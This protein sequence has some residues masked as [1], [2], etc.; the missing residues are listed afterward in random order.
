MVSQSVG[1]GVDVDVDVPVGRTAKPAGAR[2]TA[3]L[4]AFTLAT[5]LADG[6]TKIALPVLATRST[7]SPALISLV[8]LTLTLPWLLVALPVGVLVDRADRRRLLWLADGLRLLTIGGLIAIVLGGRATLGVLALGGL[9]LGVAEVIALTATSALIPA[10]VPRADRER[11]NALITGAETAANEFAGPFVGGL[12]LAAGTGLALGVTWVAYL[13]ASLL[14]LLLTGRFRAA[15]RAGNDSDV[16]STGTDGGSA[17][18]DAPEAAAP[19][20]VA[21][22]IGAGL[23]FLRRHRLL[24][25][26]SLILTVLCA[27]WGGWLALMPLVAHDLMRLSAREYGVVLSAL[28]VGGLL[29]ALVVGRLN[30]LIGHR[31]VMLAD[32]VGTFAM[33]A[34]PAVTT[35]LWAVAAAAFVGGLGGT[36]WSVDARLIGQNL[37]PEHM[38]GRYSGAARLLGWGA[39][40]L[41]AGLIGVLAQWFGVR[42]A[43]VVFAI[44]VAATIPVYLRVVTA[45]RLAPALRVP[46][47]TADLG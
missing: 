37:V 43:F 21:G 22:Q 40:P 31:R 27:S 15:G 34:V 45:E 41:G 11:A 30:R 28:G 35:N 38:M 44:A 13:A 6:I 42:A 33:M 3:V 39:M 4:L 29:G 46:E 18:S 20:S 16:T 7:D 14:L 47:P 12:L 5:N 24:R 25:T 2:N 17:A 1:V 10:I 19:E 9:V 26:M 36:L 32:L 23:G 8:S